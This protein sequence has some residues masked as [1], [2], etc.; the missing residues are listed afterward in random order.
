M[1]RL[2]ITG[3]NGALVR[4]LR[5]QLAPLAE[6]L[7][8]SDRIEITDPGPNEEIVTCDLAD[9]AAVE[10]MV[11]G[12]DGILHLGGISVEAPFEPILQAN[13]IGLYNLY[14]AA[15]RHGQP[16]IIFASSNHTI[17]FYPQGQ[18][19]NNDSPYRPDSLYGVSKI[20]GEAI[21]RLYFDKFGQQSALLRIGSAT[22]VP[23]DHRAL[24]TWLS[25]DDLISLIAAIF[26]APDFGCQVVWGVSAND[27]GWWDNSHLEGLDWQPRDN[28]EAYRA[29]IEAT[30]PLPRPD[31]PLRRWQGGEFTGIPIL[32]ICD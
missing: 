24:S 30:V 18:R 13:I 26:A 10:A 16:R 27:A 14:E 7:R 31:E 32:Q 2:L 9:A 23:Q 21:A 1:K 20:F 28:A 25:P 5:S 15:R 17:G 6:C 19:L 22:E 29:Q 3:A 12:C 8:L 4:R 11:A